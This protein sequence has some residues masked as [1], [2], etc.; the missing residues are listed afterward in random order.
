MNSQTN[1]RIRD[2]AARKA[3]QRMSPAE[4]RELELLLGD[5]LQRK[6]EFEQEF[7]R[8]QQLREFFLLI[9][10]AEAEPA[11]DPRIDTERLRNYVSARK[12]KSGKTLG[13]YLL[14]AAVIGCI[15]WLLWP[16]PPL[17]TTSPSPT[18]PV[19]LTYQVE[20]NPSGPN[21]LAQVKNNTDHALCCVVRMYFTGKIRGT[22]KED[23][24]VIL[25]PHEVRDLKFR[26]W[27]GQTFDRMEIVEP[28]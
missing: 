23:Q 28:R 4:E 11:T 20:D 18:P 3:A 15:V 5:D 1:D 7:A 6:Q 16:A 22:R 12:S 21:Y 8:A 25:Q 10:A 24:Q 14:I 2:L 27:L 19:T 13:K 26:L 17:P 9:L